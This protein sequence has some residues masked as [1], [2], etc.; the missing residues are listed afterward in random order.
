[1]KAILKTIVAVIVSGVL[2]PC[3]S[4]GLSER[5]RHSFANNLK[6]IIDSKA[7]YVWGGA[8]SEQK[9]LDCSGYIYLAARRSGMPVKRTTALFMERGL[10]G[11]SGKPLRLEDCEETDLIWWTWK[12]SPSRVH[13]HVGVF[14]VD[15]DSGLLEVTH[16]SSGKGVVIQPLTGK[17]LRDI[18]SIRRLTIGDTRPGY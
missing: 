5:Y 8:E 6:T 16:A 15:R 9:G 3:D 12:T 13:G 4:L 1:M 18:S 2:T 10:G 14:L 17:L 7:A 11:W